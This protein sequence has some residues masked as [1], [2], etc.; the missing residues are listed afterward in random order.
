MDAPENMTSPSEEPQ[1]PGGDTIRTLHE[2]TF[3]LS[4]ASAFGYALLV[5]ASRNQASWTPTNDSTYYFLRSA[6]RINDL[7]R[8]PSANSVSTSAVARE[9]PSRWSQV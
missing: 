8:L 1:P 9:Y 6:F 7:L 3:S 2:F 5:Y 4:I